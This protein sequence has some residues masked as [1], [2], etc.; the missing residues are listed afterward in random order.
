MIRAE[1]EG[2]KELA[3]GERVSAPFELQLAWVSQT[4]GIQVLG[5]NPDFKLVGKMHRALAVHRA[6][7]KEIKDRTP[8]DWQTIRDTLAVL[9]EWKSG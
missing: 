8:N 3:T 6:F 4:W 7:E 9:E 5:A 1:A 2:K